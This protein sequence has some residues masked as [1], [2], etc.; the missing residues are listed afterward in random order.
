MPSTPLRAC[1]ATHYGGPR[2]SD[3][4]LLGSVGLEHAEGPLLYLMI[5]SGGVLSQRYGHNEGDG[6]TEDE[7]VTSHDECGDVMLRR[8]PSHLT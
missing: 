5:V 6:Q 7:G 2:P 4:V 8:M 1:G 3:S